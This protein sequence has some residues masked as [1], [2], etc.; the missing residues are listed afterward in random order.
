[1]EDK[2]KSFVIRNSRAGFFT[3]L[4][5]VS[6]KFE[7]A[8]DEAM[9]ILS[10]LLADNTLEIVHD[11]FGEAKLCEAGRSY[12]VMQKELQRRS[13]KRRPKKKN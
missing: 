3:K 13:E 12:D 11:D 2:I 8:Q 4:T 9:S 1:M 6:F 5:T 10:M 7:I